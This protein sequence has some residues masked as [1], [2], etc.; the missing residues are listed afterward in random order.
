MCFVGRLGQGILD[1]FVTI[2]DTVRVAYWS[3]YYTIQLLRYYSNDIYALYDD[4]NY[5]ITKL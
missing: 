4:E 2:I 5:F 1:S 3:L